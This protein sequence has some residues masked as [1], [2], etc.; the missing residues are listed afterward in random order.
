M[1]VSEMGKVQGWDWGRKDGH[2]QTV[3]KWGIKGEAQPGCVGP[4]EG[5]AS[6]T[7]PRK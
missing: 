7:E 3:D 4:G 1:T 6:D 5:Q 2:T